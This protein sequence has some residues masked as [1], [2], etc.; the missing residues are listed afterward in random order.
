MLWSTV[1]APEALL[2]D[3]EGG[4]E[5]CS[6]ERVSTSQPQAVKENI[7]HRRGEVYDI[8]R[9]GPVI[10]GGQSNEVQMEIKASQAQQKPVL[11]VTRSGDKLLRVGP[12]GDVAVRGA[13][14]AQSTQDA[15]TSANSA[16][17]SAG[18]LSVAKGAVIGGRVKIEET[19][20]ASASGSG[21]LQVGGG[22][23]VE[24]RAFFGGSV[25]VGRLGAG[26]TG[27]RSVKVQ[28]TDDEAVAIVQAGAPGKQ[29]SLQLWGADLDG[30]RLVASFAN[31]NG[32]VAID[33]GGSGLTI[34]GGPTFVKDEKDAHVT[35]TGKLAASLVA[36]GGVVIGK[37]LH[38]RG[39]ISVGEGLQ[40]RSAPGRAVR[41][42]ADFGPAE[43]LLVPGTRAAARVQVGRG[44][45]LQGT[46]GGVMEIIAGAQ[47]DGAA[48]GSPSDG[49]RSDGRRSTGSLLLSAG[50]PDGVQLTHGRMRSG[51]GSVLQLEGQ[52]GVQVASHSGELLLAARGDDGAVRIRAGDGPG[53]VLQARAGQSSGVDLHSD[54]SLT[55]S[56]S[57][58]E[59]TLLANDPVDGLLRLLSNGTGEESVLVT[60][61]A[62]GIRVHAGS[63]GLVLDSDSEVTVRLPEAAV[64]R[65]AATGS[66][67]AGSLPSPK[68]GRAAGPL[69]DPG[70]SQ[71]QSKH[72]CSPTALSVSS[73]GKI[74]V[75]GGRVAGT[76]QLQRGTAS[77]RTPVVTRNSVVLLTLV[78]LSSPAPY[79]IVSSKT[80]GVGFEVTAV[81]A[82]GD[83]VE[84]DSSTFNWLVL[85]ALATCEWAGWDQPPVAGRAM[86][87]AEA[88]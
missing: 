43:V 55:I 38:V 5:V 40:P 14:T 69:P 67:T 77:I 62:G 70:S 18:G 47:A 39:D 7:V 74:S 72:S 57:E 56:G 66:G 51:P 30:R 13:L 27:A 4:A 87:D 36:T 81:D 32:T 24:K 42:S 61:P 6:V 2:E 46:D 75:A 31:I 49:S 60:A 16:L 26:N 76:A 53:L 28:S 22:L 82:T 20:D 84:R 19:Q 86:P 64:F 45:V 10:V 34:Q 78:A 52:T 68:V 83:I 59:V 35:A 17:V 33:S 54:S 37:Q 79:H 63:K 80:E 48:S 29:A 85:D 41:I 11:L 50:G 1:V 44:G 65:I 9:M 8:P 15:L 88:V 73:Q 71:K 25:T 12:T 21:A 23:A 58:G 3:C